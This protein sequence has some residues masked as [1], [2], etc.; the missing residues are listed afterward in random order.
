MSKLRQIAEQLGISPSTVSRALRNHSRISQDVRT[1]VIALA[2][3]M[4]YVPNSAISRTMRQIRSGNRFMQ[5]II[6]IWWPGS[7]PEARLRA[8]YPH[9][10]TVLDAIRDTASRQHIALET[11]ETIGHPENE[12]TA[13]RIFAARGVRGIIL[14]PGLPEIYNVPEPFANFI[15]VAIG[16]AVRGQPA[17]RVSNNIETAYAMIFNQ[18]RD[19]GYRRPG[20]VLRSRY[21]Q[22]SEMRILGACHYYGKVL[23]AFETISLFRQ[24]DE[25][26]TIPPQK[27]LRWIE[28]SELDSAF[29]PGPVHC[30]NLKAE[31]KAAGLN[32]VGCVSTGAV[33]AHPTVSG[34]INSGEIM[35]REAILALLSRL[36]NPQY[37]YAKD[38][39]PIDLFFDSTWQE[40]E[41]L[42]V[43]KPPPKRGGRAS[44][45]SK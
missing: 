19:R 27:L 25:S 1:R 32:R 13:A 42:P 31:L 17:V 11:V 33:E 36:I 18:L 41:T 22:L 23:K 16:N 29:L 30:K 37:Q 9:F 21:D 3:Q 10:S 44:A 7:W 15:C 12:R 39:T 45:V 5:E 14:L 34:P 6:G 20:L 26:N 40:G 38:D 8:S 2:N 35:G 28:K 24:T 4:E 43:L